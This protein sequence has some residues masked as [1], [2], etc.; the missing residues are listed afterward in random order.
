MTKTG[1]GGSPLRPEYVNIKDPKISAQFK[2][3][4]VEKTDPWK[5]QPV[6]MPDYRGEVDHHDPDQGELDLGIPSHMEA[7]EDFFAKRIPSK[8]L[9]HEIA[10]TDM[11]ATAMKHVARIK[12]SKDQGIVGSYTGKT[13]TIGLNP[14]GIRNSGHA[15]RDVLLHEIGHSVDH[16]AFG[17]TASYKNGGEPVLE[18]NADGLASRWGAGLNRLERT[19]NRAQ[20]SAARTQALETGVP[21]RHRPPVAGQMPLWNEQQPPGEGPK[22]VF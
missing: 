14:L 16:G 7:R 20:Y 22:V 12:P 1:N 10:H 21:M 19:G 18:G 5:F 17:S 9:A 8:A 6:S 13:K 2:Q 15:A 3:M 4:L 11:P